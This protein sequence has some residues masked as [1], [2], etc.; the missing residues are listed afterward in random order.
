MSSVAK[1]PRVGDSSTLSSL[2]YDIL[3]CGGESL[4]ELKPLAVIQRVLLKTILRK[5]IRFSTDDILH[6]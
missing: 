2:Q 3:A 6:E 1:G 4:A 5:P